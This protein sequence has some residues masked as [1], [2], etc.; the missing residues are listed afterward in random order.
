MYE[1][2]ECL[3]VPSLLSFIEFHVHVN[4][5]NIKQKEQ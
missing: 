2:M 3:I 1:H 4:S 5:L